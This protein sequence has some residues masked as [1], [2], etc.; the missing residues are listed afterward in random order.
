MH[1]S[2]PTY[3]ISCL[4]LQTAT[5]PKETYNHISVCYMLLSLYTMSDSGERPRVAR[6]L[7]YFKQNHK[8]SACSPSTL[9]IL[10]V[11]HQGRRPSLV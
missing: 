2:I 9:L 11:A 6:I 10:L 8:K 7:D 4:S 5:K 1:S 3:K